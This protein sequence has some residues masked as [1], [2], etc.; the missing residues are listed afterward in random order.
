MRHE[1]AKL[2]LPQEAYC[3]GACVDAGQSSTAAAQPLGPLDHGPPLEEQQPCTSPVH[4]NIT[5]HVRTRLTFR[6]RGRASGCT[7]SKHGCGIQY[8]QAAAAGHALL[9][10]ADLHMACLG[11]LDTIPRQSEAMGPLPE[12]KHAW[13]RTHNKHAH[14]VGS[15]G[16]KDELR[17]AMTRFAS[18]L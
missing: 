18:L 8:M 16:L 1:H 4:I 6:V 15:R 12:Q 5:L 9:M 11:M 13:A 10:A 3:T 7:L 14:D 17:K 2:C